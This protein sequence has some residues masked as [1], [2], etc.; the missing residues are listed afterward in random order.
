[1]SQQSATAED[2][3]KHA[4]LRTGPSGL[5]FGRSSRAPIHLRLFRDRGTK[6]F[7]N[8]PEYV[9]WLLATRCVAMGCHLSIFSGDQGRWRRLSETL[10]RA[11]ATVDV[12]DQAAKLPGRGRPFRPSLVIDDSATGGLDPGPW[13]VV[14]A[15]HD[16]ASSA[17]VGELR[18]SDLALLGQL[19][20]KALDQ[21]RRA[22]ALNQAQSRLATSLG[23]SEYLLASP[24]RAIKVALQP[25]RAEYQLLFERGD[26]G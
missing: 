2:T 14:A 25:G 5:S 15:R 21:V 17:A 3:G 19:E 18:G 4:V 16:P 11:G 8:P 6:V 9:T 26:R 1:M 20:G 23:A 22:Y 7:L 12:V 10:T 24:R 13:Q